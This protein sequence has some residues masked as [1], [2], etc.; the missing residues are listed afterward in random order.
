MSE[1]AEAVQT[2]H[3]RRDLRTEW[4]DC[5]PDKKSAFGQVPIC[6]VLALSKRCRF[7]QKSSH[8]SG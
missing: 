1:T 3:F 2:L 5:D 7:L 8:A 6:S 4:G